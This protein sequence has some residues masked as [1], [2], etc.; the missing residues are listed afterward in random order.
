MIPITEKMLLEWAGE[1]K[2]AEARRLLEREQFE[3]VSIQWPVVHGTLR[4]NLR[5]LRTGFRVVHSG[6]IESLCPCYESR[7]RGIVCSHVIA[8]A[9]EVRKRLHDPELERRRAEEQS[10]AEFLARQAPTG[11]L[12]RAEPGQPAVVGRLV[13]EVAPNWYEQWRAGS[14]RVRAWWVTEGG[15]TPLGDV[16]RDGPVRLSAEDE[17]RLFVWEDIGCG[18]Q[19]ELEVSRAEFLNLLDVL[20][21]EGFVF[22]AGAGQ[23]R[24]HRTTRV[25]STLALDLDPDTGELVLRV[26]TPIPALEGAAATRHI[27]HRARGWAGTD[28]DLWPL[29]QVVPEPV[30]AVYDAPARIARV[31]VPQ[32]LRNE[33]VAITARVP[34]ESSVDASMLDLRPA[35]PRFHLVLRGS[36]ASLTATLYA[37]YDGTRLVAGKSDP[38]GHFA[39]PDPNDLLRYYVRNPEAEAAALQRLARA[40]LAGPVGDQLKPLIGE[41]QVINFLASEVPGLRRLGWNVIVEGR[42]GAALEDA[43]WAVPVV[44]ITPDRAH[45]WFDVQVRFETQ[46][47]HEVPAT[48][49]RRALIKGESWVLL[50]GRRVWVDGSAVHALDRVFH[51]CEVAE[52]ARPGSFRLRHVYAGYVYAA[53]RGLDGVD[54]EAPKSWLEQVA[55]WAQGIAPADG[56][57]ALP[58]ALARL[59]RPYQMEGVRWLRMLEQCGFAGILADD[60]GLGKTL[61]TLAWLAMER[62][63]PNARGLPALVVCPTSLIENWALEAARFT[64]SLRVQIMAGPERHSRW[65]ECARGDLLIT[66]YALLRRDIDRWRQI[67]LSVAVLDEAQHIKN[68]TTRNA[69]AAKELKA[70]HRLVLTGTP[71]ENSV[72][73][74]WSIMDFLMPGYLGTAE[75]FRRNYELPIAQGGEEGEDALRRLRWKLRPFVLR[76]MKREVARELPPKIEQTAWCALS[77]DQARVYDEIY[78]TSRERLREVVDRVGFEAARIEV[79]R[80][81]LR[82]RQVCCH[83]ELLRLPNAAFESPSSKMEL[84]FELLDE[85]LDGGHRVVVFSQFVS[86][87][88][89]IRRE[90]ERRGWAY[91]YLD[92]STTDRLSVVHRF[93]QDR[94]IPVFLISLRA[95]GTGLNLVGA[96]TVILYDPWWNPAVEQQ[97]MDRVYRIGQFRTVYSVRLVTRGTVEERVVHLQRRKQ[98]LANSTVQAGGGVERWTWEDIRQLLDL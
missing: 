69:I 78:R 7:E 25:S 72:A 90:L 65:D 83:L 33:R 47:G 58:D 75:S 94:S 43:V 86:M 26:R 88:T 56:L 49:V 20:G 18:A 34:V 30:Q 1:R 67:P 38:A 50:E 98:E 4:N 2:L 70:Y 51:D 31:A 22:T 23:L 66:S 29:A 27:V 55:K 95:G 40:G 48:E 74:L 8:L 14:V 97:A 10:R 39:I 53:L 32:F 85:A 19:S 24:V 37:E 45:R 81:L 41:R 60:M 12:R 84:L 46:D 15:R 76:R 77:P 3:D 5:A 35:T 28:T 11:F 62:I 92:G 16:P 91:S 13:W 59:L 93:N 87:L 9:L 80:T 71:L 17:T 52:G 73:D 54:V 79:L 63:H 82:L 36:L 21:P 6:C 64:P 96:D 68:R 44:T 42:A 57:V 89:L 61:Q